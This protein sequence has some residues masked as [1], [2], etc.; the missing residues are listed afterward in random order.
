MK[1]LMTGFDPFGGEKLNPAF[2]AVKLLPDV[3]EGAEIIKQ[4]IPTV[5]TKCGVVLKAA[6]EE[7][8]PD[9]ILCVGQ[10]GGRSS[11]SVEKVAINLAEA[12]IPDNEK[13][14]PRGMALEADGAT[15]YFSS[16]PIKAIVK[17][18]R[19]QGIPSNISYTAGTFVCNAIMYRLLYMIERDYRNLR[20]GFIHVPFDTA[21][22]TEKP[23]GTPSMPIATIA[24]GLEC[25]VSAI[26]LNDQD[27]NEVAGTTH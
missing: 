25:A 11:I 21:Q 4:E 3:I 15:A 27:I 6:I 16:L 14:Q 22:V 1:I 7:H 19:A 10:A 2:E 26:V 5:F 13:Q 18:V 17:A 8:Q 20:G 23:E 9:V 12:R 24:K